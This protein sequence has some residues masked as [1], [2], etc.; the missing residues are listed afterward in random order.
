M[1]KKEYKKPESAG[2]KHPPLHSSHNIK[3]ESRRK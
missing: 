3:Y 2:G 1:K